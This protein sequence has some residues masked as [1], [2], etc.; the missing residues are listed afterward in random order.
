MCEKKGYYAVRGAS[1]CII[2]RSRKIRQA[3]VYALL[4]RQYSTRAIFKDVVIILI[5][6]NTMEDSETET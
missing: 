4:E 3:I 5:E 1:V 2:S 6:R